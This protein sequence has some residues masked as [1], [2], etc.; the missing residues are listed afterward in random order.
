MTTDAVTW[1][2]LLELDLDLSIVQRGR[3]VYLQGALS[4]M[5][6]QRHA[7]LELT[8]NGLCQGTRVEPYVLNVHLRRALPSPSMQGSCSCPVGATGTCKHIAALVLAW[9]HSRGDFRQ[10]ILSRISS[11]DDQEK[12][13]ALDLI[14]HMYPQTRHIL[15]LVP[16]FDD[17]LSPNDVVASVLAATS[18]QAASVSQRVYRLW[19][20][21]THVRRSFHMQHDA[22]LMDT[23]SAIVEHLAHPPKAWA[24]V[25]EHAHLLLEDIVSHVQSWLTAPGLTPPLTRELWGV[26]IT[27][28]LC[29]DPL[30]QVAKLARDALRCALSEPERAQAVLFVRQRLEAC[31]LSDHALL[32]QLEDP[33]HAAYIERALALGLIHAAALRALDHTDRAS[34][35]A[36]FGHTISDDELL[37]VAQL[38]VA[39]GH[40]DWALDA[41]E[42]RFARSEH[43]EL[44]HWLETYYARHHQWVAALSV[45]QSRFYTE[46]TVACVDAIRTYALALEQWP[47]IRTQIIHGLRQQRALDVLLH[48][49]VQDGELEQAWHTVEFGQREGFARQPQWIRACAELAR[50]LEPAFPQRALVLYHQVAAAMESQ[51]SFSKD[52]IVHMRAEAQKMKDTLNPRST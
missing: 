47:V 29:D 18:E 4:M 5:M 30:A 28:G 25:P 45:A 37:G 42:R 41:V 22:Q 10:D 34:L 44:S 52:Y 15:D 9:A 13:R 3:A 48:M 32:L 39:H 12:T 24:H 50:A 26:L 20:L 11:L 2:E 1:E 31:D 35:D 17:S 33:A 49:H 38:C 43:Q 16:G 27:L 7:P 36:I 6:F 19:P 23:L 46:A 51:G 40:D 8:L 14:L 21:W